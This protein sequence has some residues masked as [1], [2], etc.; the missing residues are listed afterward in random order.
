[1][2][3]L[4]YTLATDP[5]NMLIIVSLAIV[6]GLA[7]AR[8]S[9]PLDLDVQV[10]W[11]SQLLRLELS[12]LICLRLSRAQVPISHNAASGLQQHRLVPCASGI[13]GQNGLLEMLPPDV[14]F[15]ERIECGS[16]DIPLDWADPDIGYTQIHYTRYPAA[17]DVKREGTIFVD[18]GMQAVLLCCDASAATG[19]P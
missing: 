6:S 1:M 8:L 3:V 4:A 18:P 10:G 13:L 15:S 5:L 19:D 12:K 14:S 11:Y 2:L 17:P 7:A 9:T 16:F